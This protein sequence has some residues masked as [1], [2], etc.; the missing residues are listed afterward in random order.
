M[1]Q[2]YI[3]DVIHKVFIFTQNLAD[4]EIVSLCKM[5]LILYQMIDMPN[6]TSL[7]LFPRGSIKRK[8]QVQGKVSTEGNSS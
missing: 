1:L 4:F 8:S 7:S 3:L 2:E 5:S 6:D